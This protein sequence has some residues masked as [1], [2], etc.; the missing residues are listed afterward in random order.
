MDETPNLTP[1]FSLVK[2]SHVIQTESKELEDHWPQSRKYEEMIVFYFFPPMPGFLPQ[3]KM[4]FV[5]T[6]TLP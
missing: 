6:I 2:V 5:F 4:G 1:D 3:Y